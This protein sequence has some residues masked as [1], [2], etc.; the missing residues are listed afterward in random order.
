MD[1]GHGGELCRYKR[2]NSIDKWDSLPCHSLN[3]PFLVFCMSL[4]SCLIS[5]PRNPQYWGS[6][7]CSSLN[8]EFIMCQC[9]LSGLLGHTEGSVTARL[10]P[11]PTDLEKQQDK[12]PTLIPR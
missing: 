9:F 5:P 1:P 10:S 7:H 6:F 4:G 12:I 2:L 11:T 8:R 3:P